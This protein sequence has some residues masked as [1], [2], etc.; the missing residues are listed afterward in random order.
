MLALIL[1]IALVGS[2]LWYRYSGSA[3]GAAG[4]GAAAP[5][6]VQGDGSA[7]NGKSVKGGDA[8]KAGGKGAGR[9]GAD[10]ANRV[11][12][13]S[14]AAI[15]K[16]DLAIYLNA[17]GTVTPL[18]TVTVH[19]RVDGELKKLHFS[20]GQLVHEGDVLAEIDPRPF[21]V[22]FTQMEGQRMRDQALLD[23]ARIDLERYR[24]LFAQDSIAQQQ[25]DTQMSLVRQ[26]E[27]TVQM[28][29]GQVD[30]ARLQLVY[31][32]VTAPITGR[33]GLR[34]VDQ[35]NIVHASDSNGMAVITQLQP[36]SVVFPIPQD[37]LPAVA[38][39]QAA[40]RLPVE[41]WDREQKNRLARGQLYAID[42]QID[43]TTGTV[44]LKA[45]FDNTDSALFANQFVNVRLLVDTLRDVT[46]GPISAVQRGGQGV[47]V[48]V[49]NAEMTVSVRTVTV[50]VN[51]AGRVQFLSGVEPGDRVVIDGMDRLREGAKVEIAT[52]D[53]T[54]TPGR[55]RAQ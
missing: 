48:Y 23:N 33:I 3:D 14:A 29:K 34:T 45:Q 53:R 37:N 52:A 40:V 36:I 38:R 13:V 22:Q 17:L 1:I 54:T 10:P 35:G 25:V 11:T 19:T 20:E 27:G 47:F 30:N 49:V 9:F 4:Q 12:P 46:V 2:A 28:D 7:A 18:R 6:S 16:G 44:K 43:V 26:L 5:G 15:V 8:A 50:G 21:E 39:R 31:A 55:R 41:A 32:K 24:T 42:N 51:E